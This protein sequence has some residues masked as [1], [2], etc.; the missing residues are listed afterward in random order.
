MFADPRAPCVVGAGGL[1]KRL[2]C[3]AAGMASLGEGESSWFALLED[4]AADFDG[5]WP[6]AAKEP[7]GVPLPQGAAGETPR[8]MQE[9]PAWVVAG[10][11]MEHGLPGPPGLHGDVTDHW[12]LEPDDGQETCG[13]DEDCCAKPGSLAGGALAGGRWVDADA[14]QAAAGNP[15]RLSQGQQRHRAALKDGEETDGLASEPPWPPSAAVGEADEP[16]I[17][18]CGLTRTSTPSLSAAG[19]AQ[20]RKRKYSSEENSSERRRRKTPAAQGDEPVLPF[21]ES[22][23]PFTLPTAKDGRP[24]PAGPWLAAMMV[25]PP[26]RMPPATCR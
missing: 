19:Q 14:G 15:Q 1:P 22:R 9:V 5:D 23:A 21:A 7:N 11:D 10:A 16:Q 25:R 20:E 18:P 8:Q 2:R 17:A 4:A 24:K 12:L 26:A 6:G 13:S 3:G